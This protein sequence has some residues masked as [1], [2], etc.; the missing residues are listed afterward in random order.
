[1]FNP[2]KGA[3]AR[4]VCNGVENSEVVF[5]R[6]P[7]AQLPSLNSTLSCI[8][9]GRMMYPSAA[10][11]AQHV[12]AHLI[13]DQCPFQCQFCKVSLSIPDTDW[14]MIAHLETSHFQEL[15]SELRLV[16][17]DSLD[18]AV[19]RFFASAV[20]QMAGRGLHIPRGRA[21]CCHLCREII[22]ISE[23]LTVAKH[24]IAHLDPNEYLPD[25]TIYNCRACG[26]K[27]IGDRSVI[28]EYSF[29]SWEFTVKFVYTVKTG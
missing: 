23:R 16:Q 29:R 8:Y 24:I 12:M 5:N 26:D 11:Q 19:S 28:L 17:E 1:M 25:V 21:V 20:T 3:T 18:R 13:A 27:P 9:C 22:F 2:I 15:I 7:V 14:R 6:R 10:K 4:L